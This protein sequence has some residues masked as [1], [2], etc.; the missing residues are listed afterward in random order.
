[1]APV[2]RSAA[3]ALRH[4]AGRGA[5][6]EKTVLDAA[7]AEKFKAGQADIF[8]HLLNGLTAAERGRPETYESLIG[9]LQ[10]DKLA[11]RE[12]AAERL[13]EL[14]PAG[15]SIAYDAAAAPEMR[16]AAQAAWRKLIPEGS[17]PKAEK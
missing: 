6:Q 9:Y 7:T 5:E 3:H 1:A 10:N 13:V 17:L 15:K 14:V 4:F 16:G 2:R 8:L 11:I 12:L